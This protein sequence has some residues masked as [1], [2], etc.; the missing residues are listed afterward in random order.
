MDWLHT[1]FDLYMWPAIVVLYYT[2]VVFAV[3]KILL[4]NK[5]PLKTYSYLL[6][7]VLVPVVGLLI[8]FFFGQDYRKNKFYSRKMAIDETIV[9]DLVNSQLDMAYQHELIKDERVLDKINVIQLLLSSDRAFLTRNNKVT[10]LV[11][12]EVKF[13]HLRK[14]LE[15]AERNIH[16]EYYIFEEDEIGNEIAEILIRKAKEGVD[17]RFIYDDVGSKVSRRLKARFKDAGV[18]AFAIM[19]VYFPKLSKAN[20]R[21]HRKIVVIDGKLGYVGGINIADRYINKQGRNYW[22][23]THLKIEGNA[24]HALQIAFLLNWFYASNESMEFKR[25]LFPQIPPMGNH[26]VQIAGSGPDSDWASIMQAFFMAITSAKKRVWITTPYFIPNEP[27]LTAIKT[28]SLSGIDVQIIFPYKPDSK[29]VHAASMSYMKEVLE[30]GVKVHLYTKGFI[31]SKTLIIDNILSSV[32]TANMDFRSFD[33]NYEINAMIY[34]K[35]FNEQLAGQFKQD[36]GHCIPLQ[37][38]R[39]QQRPVRT[40]LLESIARLLAPIL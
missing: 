3:I 31:H 25:D 33:Q 37:L 26:C 14:D 4:E 30:S 20:Y 36:M 15:K 38:S 2:L 8:Y 34:N 28:A 32:G 27:V 9:E 24:V 29:M 23:D 22:R 40:R 11:N 7:L 19:P 5:N 6:I 13:D 17:V 39:W 10:M 1:H 35:E 16:L 18:K 12:G 21:D